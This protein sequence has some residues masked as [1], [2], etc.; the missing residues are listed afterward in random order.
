MTDTSAGPRR[1]GQ[2]G[3]AGIGMDLEATDTLEKQP[4]EEEKSM[5]RVESQASQIPLSRGRTITLVLSLTGAAFLNTLSNQ[6]SVII[7]P[8]IGRD[9]DI[10]APRQQW[11]VSSYSLAFGCFLLLWGRLA[12]VYGKR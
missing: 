3:I 4:D 6:A 8:T 1:D 10:P 12:D 5:H 9:L 11:I 7:L 2:D